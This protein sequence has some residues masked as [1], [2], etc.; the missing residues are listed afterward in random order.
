MGAIDNVLRRARNSGR[1]VRAAIGLDTPAVVEDLVARAVISEMI[2]ELEGLVR[3]VEHI[4]R[5]EGD[6]NLAENILDRLMLLAQ[7]R[8]AALD[9][10]KPRE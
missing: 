9:A 1:V 2:R 3:T 7:I 5:A 4:R 8:R 6:A 10:I